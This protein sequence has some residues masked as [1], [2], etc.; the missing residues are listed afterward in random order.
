MEIN[1]YKYRPLPDYPPA[2]VKKSHVEAAQ[3]LNKGQEP[4]LSHEIRLSV[5]LTEPNL[6]AKRFSKP[7]LDFSDLVWKTPSESLLTDDG[8]HH[9]AK[10]VEEQEF[11]ELAIGDLTTL[12]PLLN[13]LKTCKGVALLDL[14]CLTVMKPLENG[15]WHSYAFKR[16]HLEA[17]LEIFSNPN[18][19]HV[20]LEVQFF[21][22]ADLPL[23]ATFLDTHP[24]AAKVSAY[25]DLTGMECTWE[26][27]YAVE[28]NRATLESP[29]G[30][31]SVHLNDGNADGAMAAMTGLQTLDLTSPLLDLSEIGVATLLA[32]LL[33]PTTRVHT[34]KLG[35][36]PDLKPILAEL[37]NLRLSELDIRFA[38][39]PYGNGLSCALRPEDVDALVKVEESH[40]KWTQS[41]LINS[42]WL[43]L[44]EAVKLYELLKRTGTAIHDDYTP[45]IPYS[46]LPFPSESL[47]FK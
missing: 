40:P 37:P 38:S 36:V 14:R 27:G 44:E 45:V 12:T 19:G 28:R 1:R 11:A 18:I 46:S 16:E 23:L 43:P 47:S 31:V 22:N 15:K 8:V 33:H 21:S 17:L 20:L 10:L 3:W 5:D 26:T 35:E 2:D 24:D 39:V 25:N 30:Q 6:K 41:L 34:V 4:P 32:V 7:E 42:R 29:S 9:L 13:A